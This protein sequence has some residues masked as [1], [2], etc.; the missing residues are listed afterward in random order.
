MPRTCQPICLVACALL[1][2]CEPSYLSSEPC[3]QEAQA[4]ERQLRAPGYDTAEAFQ[5]LRARGDTAAES[6]VVAYLEGPT[7]QDLALFRTWDAHAY[8]PRP[9]EPWL[10][11]RITLEQAVLIAGTPNVD[12]VVPGSLAPLGCPA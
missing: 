9:D 5:Q 4:I 1:L 3:L 2:A 7:D 10:E 11:V 12:R 6:F 8:F